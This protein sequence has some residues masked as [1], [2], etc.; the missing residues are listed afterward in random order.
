MDE[1]TQA[2]PPRATLTVPAH[3]TLQHAVALEE[4]LS[5]R[6]KSAVEQLQRVESLDEEQRA[7][8]QAILEAMQHDSRNHAEL[9]G[10][11]VGCYQ[12]RSDA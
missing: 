6:V 3:K 5:A 10:N 9:V 8:I 7:E 12:G 11:L 2:C 1:P 4:E